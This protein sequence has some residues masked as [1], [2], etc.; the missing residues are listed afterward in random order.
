M[1]LHPEVQAKAHTE[2][3]G[4][5]GPD[6]LPNFDDLPRLPYIRAIVMETLRWMPVT[7]FGMPH[8][9]MEDDVYKGYH[10]PKG[11]IVVPVSDRSIV[12]S[13]YDRWTNGGTER[14]GHAAQ[15]GRL[16]GARILQT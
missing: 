5:V 11:A 10:V 12:L 15:P 1:A 7:P 3:H 9:L 14:V 4:E 8:R 13:R 16:P 6:R 2:L